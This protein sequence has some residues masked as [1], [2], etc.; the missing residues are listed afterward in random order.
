MVNL[1]SDLLSE[2]SKSDQPDKASSL[3]SVLRPLQALDRPGTGHAQRYCR[4]Q[5]PTLLA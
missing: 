2:T 3:V 4:A 1:E 5:M